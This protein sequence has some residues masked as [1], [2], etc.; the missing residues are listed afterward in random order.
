MKIQNLLNWEKPIKILCFAN[1]PPK[2]IIKDLKQGLSER[3]KVTGNFIIQTITTDSKKILTKPFLTLPDSSSLKSI[4]I[5][6]A[7]NV[8]LR[9]EER[10]AITN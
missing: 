6:W 5:V 4:Y 7:I 2:D 1:D 10:L 8:N 3:M 9:A